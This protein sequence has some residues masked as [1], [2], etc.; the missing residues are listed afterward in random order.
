MSY[1]KRND[2]CWCGSGLKYKKC[3]LRR[4][5]Q[6]PENP[7]AIRKNFFDLQKQEFCFCESDA[8]NCS[9]VYA[10]SHSISKSGCLK[11]IAERSHVAAVEGDF[12][13]VR[14]RE[15]LYE[16]LRVAE[17][18]TNKASTFRGFCSFHD[19]KLFAQLDRLDFRDPATFF[20]QLFYRAAAYEKYSK[21]IAVDFSDQVRLLDKG[22]DRVI[23]QHVQFEAN[24]AKW[25]NGEGLKKLDSLMKSLESI[26][27]AE[28]LDQISYSYFLSDRRLPFAGVDCFQPSMTMDGHPLQRVNLI[29]PEE[30]FRFSPPIHSVCIAAIP[31]K[32]STLPSL[33]CLRREEKA[34]QFMESVSAET[35]HIVDLFLGAMM[36]SIE[37]VFFTPSYLKALNKNSTSVLKR[38][39]SL[40]IAEDIG[41]DDIRIARSL[42]LFKDVSIVERV[43]N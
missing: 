8:A 40:G 30:L 13:F 23:Q 12:H 39:F 36:L 20:W 6:A 4:E 16:S 1:Y 11:L 3:H 32:S 35:D 18:S 2:A 43:L 24:L 27:E 7:F 21:I 29:L 31:M 22:A 19:A 34:R 9:D 25:S 26:C 42:D 14:G 15:A 33:C 17:I 28:S 37:N 41:V 5:D 10:A 38:L